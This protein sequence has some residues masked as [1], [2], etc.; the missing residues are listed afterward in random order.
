MES[1]ASAGDLEKGG[2]TAYTTTNLSD[3]KNT[4]KNLRL[5]WLQ[6]VDVS[7][8]GKNAFVQAS[9]R[10]GDNLELTLSTLP[11]LAES[12]ARIYNYILSFL[13]VREAYLLPQLEKH[14]KPYTAE[15]NLDKTL[16]P[17]PKLNLNRISED[18]LK[19]DLGQTL[20]RNLSGGLKRIPKE[21]LDDLN[22][23]ARDESDLYIGRI[24]RSSDVQDIRP[25]WS[26][27]CYGT[28]MA[29][30]LVSKLEWLNLQPLKSQLRTPPLYPVDAYIK[31]CS[32]TLNR[33]IGMYV[34]PAAPS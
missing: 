34:C 30:I 9:V 28:I 2:N 8:D 19:R 6:V 3:G 12:T 16:F 17:E 21:D 23:V 32:L 4:Q 14:L 10:E 26:E 7:L 18:K 20:G 22:Q 25:Q 15:E 27:K 13:H 29:P 31:C 33:L 1:N 11:Q 5:L 24:S